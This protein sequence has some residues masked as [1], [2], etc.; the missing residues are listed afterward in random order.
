VGLC[1]SWE[2]FLSLKA[3]SPRTSV[4]ATRKMCLI[5]GLSYSLLKT[6]PLEILGWDFRAYGHG[7]AG[8]MA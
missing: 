8:E 4:P 1:D 2:N 3:L 5:S 6:I 7:G